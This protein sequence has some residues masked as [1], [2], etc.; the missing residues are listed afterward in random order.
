MKRQLP[1][2]EVC[3]DQQRP[4]AAGA[5]PR[6]AQSQ[7]WSQSHRCAVSR[8]TPRRRSSCCRCT[9]S[10]PSSATA[11]PTRPK[12]G[13]G[14]AR[15]NRTPQ[16]P[17]KLVAQ[18]EVGSHRPRVAVLDRIGAVE[19]EGHLICIHQNRLKQLL[20]CPRHKPANRPY[21]N[22]EASQ[23][24]LRVGII[25]DHRLIKRLVQR[26]ASKTSVG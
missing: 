20:P 9:P 24:F 19:V 23:R 1:R 15:T 21:R 10:G 2:K 22:S 16:A 18:H 14:L 5:A 11:R 26:N 17:H 25:I 4:R 13:G 3:H 8:S 12:A 7:G 6:C